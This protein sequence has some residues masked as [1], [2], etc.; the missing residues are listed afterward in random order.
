MIEMFWRQ[1]AGWWRH[2]FGVC[3]VECFILSI[4]WDVQ[5]YRVI[6]DEAGPADIGSMMR[7]RRTI[8]GD[9]SMIDSDRGRYHGW[10]L[11]LETQQRRYAR[12]DRSGAET[13]ELSLMRF[14]GLFAQRYRLRRVSDQ[15]LSSPFSLPIADA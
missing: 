12:L 9:F 15:S 1:W 6:A 2:R 10:V 11:D 3:D 8:I 13:L 7:T 14:G 4:E 5:E